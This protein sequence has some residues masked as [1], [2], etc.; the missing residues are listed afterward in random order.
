LISKS[1][2]ALPIQ[3]VIASLGGASVQSLFALLFTFHTYLLTL[4]QLVFPS[5]R[6]IPGRPRTKGNFLGESTRLLALELSPQFPFFSPAP[7]LP[8]G[9]VFRGRGWA[10]F[11]LS[12]P[13]SWSPLWF[14]SNRSPP[15]EMFMP[16]YSFVQGEWPVPSLV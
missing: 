13:K 11:P 5:A 8:P 14:P 2:L 9:S 10:A 7:F 3:I 1:I 4:S 6:I 12:K 16:L 15:D